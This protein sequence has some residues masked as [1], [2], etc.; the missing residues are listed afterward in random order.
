MRVGDEFVSDCG[1]LE[2][3]ETSSCN[4]A[5]FHLVLLFV[6]KKASW[7]GKLNPLLDLPY[8]YLM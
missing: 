8:K 4:F 5:I 7:Y 6:V 2:V 1:I 3:K